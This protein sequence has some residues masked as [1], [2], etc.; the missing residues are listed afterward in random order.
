VGAGGAAVARTYSYDAAGNLSGDGVNTY[1]YSDRGR[2]S[3][4]G[5]PRGVVSY[6]CHLPP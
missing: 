2:L 5:T 3:S 4:A 6:R 1:A